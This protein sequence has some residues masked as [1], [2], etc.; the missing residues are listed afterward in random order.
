MSKGN[1]SK[2]TIEDLVQHEVQERLNKQAKVFRLPFQLEV[3]GLRAQDAMFV[4]PVAA[5]DPEA[6]VE[7]LLPIL[8]YVETEMEEAHPGLRLMLMPETGRSKRSSAT[9]WKTPT[10]KHAWSKKKGR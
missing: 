10:G 6:P 9:R 1:G 5:T 7:M 8:S 2:T 3:R 4:L